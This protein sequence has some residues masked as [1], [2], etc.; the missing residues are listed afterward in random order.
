MNNE[1]SKEQ[2]SRGHAPEEKAL[3]LRLRLYVQVRWLVIIGVI[4]ATL[5]ATLVFQI[6][7]PTLPVYIICAVIAF[8][9][10]LLYHWTQRL[11]A[12]ETGFVIK[13]AETYGNIQIL[14]DLVTLTVLIH[15]TGCIENPL[16]FFYLAHTI[17][18]SIVLPKRRAYEIATLAI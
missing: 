6:S 12:E 9:N 4:G 17:T 5:I 2:T 16:V 15:Y 13:K 1:I 3:I 10:L 14:L 8:Y 18:A 7:F 11:K